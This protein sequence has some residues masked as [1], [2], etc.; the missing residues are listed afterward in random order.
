MALPWLRTPLTPTWPAEAD[1]NGPFS[2]AEHWWERWRRDPELRAFWWKV[3]A[4]LALVGQCGAMVVLF[5][6][7]ARAT[8]EP[9]YVYVTEKGDVR[10]VERMSGQVYKPE[11]QFLRDLTQRWVT[12]VWSIP[13]DQK[14]LAQQ[15][16]W[17]QHMATQGVN[18]QLYQFAKALQLEELVTKGYAADVSV[19]SVLTRTERVFQVEWTH[20][21]YAPQSGAKTSTRWVGEFE[22]LIRKPSTQEE[23]DANPLGVWVGR[24]TWAKKLT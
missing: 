16:R 2:A 15:W 7:V 10:G 9:Y 23:I 5:A 24:F 11:E 4:L 13:L 8:V 1:P 14:V 6:L 18:Q 19:E 12:A 17:A 20:T 3:A 22:L 21:L